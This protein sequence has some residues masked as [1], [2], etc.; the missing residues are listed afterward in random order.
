MTENYSHVG[1]G[2]E[3]D[4]RSCPNSGPFPRLIVGSNVTD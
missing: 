1:D 3:S 2:R 4:L